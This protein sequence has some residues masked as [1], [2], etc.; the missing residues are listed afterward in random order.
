[1]IITLLKIFIV[2]IVLYLVAIYPDTSRKNDFGPFEKKYIAHRGLFDNPTVPENSLPAFRKAV[3]N[4]YGIELDVQMTTDDQLVVF[5]DASL[6]RMCG[7][8]K[9]LVDCSYEELSQLRLLNSDE[10]IPLF[11]EV[12]KVLKPDI[13]LVIEIKSEG[14]YIETTQKTVEMMK[15][16]EGIYSM[17]SFSPWIIRYLRMNEPQIIRGQLSYDCVR[18]KNSKLPVILEVLGAY[19]MFNIYTKPH[20][21]AYDFKTSDNLSFQIVSRLFNA[22]CFAWTVESEEDLQKIKH[23]YRCFIFDSFIPKD[24]YPK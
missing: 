3:E 16:Y 13:P 22:E 20:Y 19:L 4:D 17:Q 23:L 5:H 9:K 12:L 1:M 11:S 14:R 21:I 7:V 8:D 18:D 24:R 15:G 2:L 6:L 10:K